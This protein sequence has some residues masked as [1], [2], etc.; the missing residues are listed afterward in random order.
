M[1][2]AT[3][4]PVDLA[5]WGSHKRNSCALLPSSFL[6]LEVFH[7]VVPAGLLFHWLKAYIVPYVTELF[8]YNAAVDSPDA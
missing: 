6:V 1:L 3:L 5:L 2:Q 7:L 8:P 4:G